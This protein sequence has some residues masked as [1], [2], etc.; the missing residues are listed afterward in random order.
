MTPAARVAAA[1]EVLDAIIS[2]ASAE[3][4]LTTWARKRRFAGSGDRAAVRDLVFGALRCRRSY[5]A[6]GGG[7]DGRGLMLGACR[8]EGA[9]VEDIFSGVDH[10]PAPLTG[11]EATHLAQ[12]VRMQEA[13]VLDC[14]DWLEAPLR[15]SLG[16]DFVP[17]MTALQSRAPVFLRVNL[18][19][20]TRAR[21]QDELTADGIVTRPVDRVETALEVL[22][23]PRKIQNAA[24][25]LEGRVELQDAASQ[26][27]VASIP[28][29]EGRVLD[30]CAGGGGKTLGLAARAP[31]AR[32]FAHDANPRRMRDLPSRAARAGVTV[33][34]LATDE[35]PKTAPFDL[36]VLDVP[37]S[38]SGSWRRAPQGKWD[39]TPERLSELR[40]VQSEVLDKATGFV[41]ENGTL[42]YITC[43]L[44]AAENA[45]QVAAFLARN[46]GWALV[47]TL[48]LTPLDGGDG[49][50]LALFKRI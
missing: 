25:Y 31:L 19:R 17:V 50:Y 5:A 9:S 6:L 20:T 23:N 11:A 48:R 46:S 43:S 7:A 26:A 49:F 4:V 47:R 38:G 10:A 15:A 24:A 16:Q 1:I 12:P 41:S 22:E 37:C 45:D 30:Y 36:V 2:G 14:P 35:V 27:V 33:T 18:A 42:A 8:A 44:L 34:L 28:V 40:A 29:P 13:V 21:V 32:F 3:Q 39:L